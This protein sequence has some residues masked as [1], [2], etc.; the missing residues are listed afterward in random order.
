MRST[1]SAVLR[2][3]AVKSE[4]AQAVMP[5]KSFCVNELAS[6]T[7]AVE[8]FKSKSLMQVGTINACST[9]SAR[10]NIAHTASHSKGDDN[11]GKQRWPL[12]GY[13]Q[14]HAVKAGCSSP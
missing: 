10:A 11:D 7:A 4:D 8:H 14:R 5:N 13:K 3:L 1:P 9:L 2:L 12:Y 6:M